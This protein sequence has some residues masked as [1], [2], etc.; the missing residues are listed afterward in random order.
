MTEDDKIFMGELMERISRGDASAQEI[1]AQRF[2]NTIYC[3][4]K[5]IIRSDEDAEDLTQETFLRVCRQDFSKKVWTNGYVYLFQIAKNLCLDRF[6]KNRKQEITFNIEMEKARRYIWAGP[7][8]VDS[9]FSR[10]TEF[11]EKLVILRFGRGYSSKEISRRAKIPKRTLE[12]RYNEIR[13]K[14][15]LAAEDAENER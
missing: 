8:A 15:R 10:L 2:Y 13:E 4:I 3:F 9:L 6:R 7:E 11:E 5:K 1:L 12:R 14:I